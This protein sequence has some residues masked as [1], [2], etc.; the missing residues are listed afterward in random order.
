[1]NRLFILGSIKFPRGTAGANYEQYFALSLMEL[2]WKVIILGVGANRKLI[3]I[4]ILNTL[5]HKTGNR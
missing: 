3:N 5:M 1:M 2:G 4:G